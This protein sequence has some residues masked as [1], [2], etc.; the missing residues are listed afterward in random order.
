MSKSYAAIAAVINAIEPSNDR[1]DVALI[2]SILA[3]QFENVAF[4]DVL[5]ERLQQIHV[6]GFDARHDLDH[7]RHVLPMAAL[8]YLEDAL[9]KLTGGQGATA[10]IDGLSPEAPAAWPWRD[11]FRPADARTN[12]VKACALLLGAIDRLDAEAE[13]E[14]AADPRALTCAA[15]GAR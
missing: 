15:H 5:R 10:P 4:A 8:T 7:G 13:G 6:H 11:F 2:R 12:L 1:P 9:T 14:A 3:F